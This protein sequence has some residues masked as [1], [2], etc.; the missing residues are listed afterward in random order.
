MTKSKTARV[1]GCLSTPGRSKTRLC[2]RVRGDLV[3]DPTLLAA[4][5]LAGLQAAFLDLASN[6][7]R[8]RGDRA[9]DSSKGH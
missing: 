8:H 6:S 2:P 5:L 9:G 1:A 4:H 3:P 7:Q